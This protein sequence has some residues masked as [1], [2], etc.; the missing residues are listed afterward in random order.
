[1]ERGVW[2]GVGAGVLHDRKG[3]DEPAV[4]LGGDGGRGDSTY[5]KPGSWRPGWAARWLPR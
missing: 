5:S 4:L 2:D 3:V 1:M